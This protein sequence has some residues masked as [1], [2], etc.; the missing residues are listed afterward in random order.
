MKTIFKITI[1][2]KQ[3]FNQVLSSFSFDPPD[4]IRTECNFFRCSIIIFIAFL[5]SCSAC[6]LNVPT[7]Y[8]L[9]VKPINDFLQ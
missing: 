4:F 5:A 6:R 3:D 7:I 2:F 9:F 8:G 1:N